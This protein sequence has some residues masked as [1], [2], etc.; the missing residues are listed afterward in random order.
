MRRHVRF[1]S[2]RSGFTLVEVLVTLTIMAILLGLSAAAYSR[3]RVVSNSTKGA[4]NLRQIHMVLMSYVQDNNS[5]LP[6]VASS[7]QVWDREP[8]APYLPLR[9]DGRENRL[10]ICP[11]AQFAGYENSNISRA[12]SATDCMIGIDPT[13]GNVAFTYGYKRNLNT[14]P[15]PANAI[16]VFDGRQQGSLRYSKE[17]VSWGAL[18][19]AGDLSAGTNPLYI[20]FR[21][22]GKAHF[23]FVDG[24]VDSWNRD[25][26]AQIT[27]LMWKG[28]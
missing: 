4:A 25:D 28:K 3:I 17:V 2:N 10:F 7:N 26:V 12:Y 16:L 23:L 18:T 19:A 8:L 22:N 11:N 9:E 13:S 15:D 6:P 24:H 5:C 1:I 14:I 20:D 21:H 27:S